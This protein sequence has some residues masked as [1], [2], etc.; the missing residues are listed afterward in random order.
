MKLQA[1]NSSYFRC[2]NIF[3]DDGLQ[4]IFVNQWTYNTSELQLDKV[5]EYATGW[6]SKVYL[7]GNFFNYMV[8]SC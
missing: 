1:F 5:T 4:N 6:K 2:K 3:C 8:L 7:N